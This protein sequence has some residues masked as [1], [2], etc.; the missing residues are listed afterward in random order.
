M[1][2]R[3]RVLSLSV[4]IVCACSA[5]TASGQSADAPPGPP[6]ESSAVPPDQWGQLPALDWVKILLRHEVRLK[7]CQPWRGG[8]AF[9]IRVPTGQTLAVS[10]W[11]SLAGGLDLGDPKVPVESWSVSRP[12][13]PAV[14]V[15][16][17]SE[18]VP[19]DVCRR[20]LC[21]MVKVSDPPPDAAAV[22]TLAAG[23]PPIRKWGYFVVPTGTT[24]ANPA[25][26]PITVY[27]AMIVGPDSHHRPGQFCFGIFSKVDPATMHDGVVLDD[28]GHVL[29][30]QT[31]YYPESYHAPVIICSAVD[32]PALVAAAKLPPETPVATPPISTRQRPP[33][34]APA[35]VV[36]VPVV[37]VPVVA[38]SRPSPKR[39]A[40][41]P[42]RS[43]LR[44]ARMYAAS[45]QYA[46]ARL[47]FQR[48]VDD[49][50]SS[51][52]AAEARG[53]LRSIQDK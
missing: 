40:D 23:P 33:T 28:Q 38:A 29:G 26:E 27:R 24:A 1:F 17:R 4:L 52:A 22:L 25:T 44:L 36:G 32:V 41:D 13:G 19:N 7:G 51:P 31:G 11:F 5:A 39:P 37:G 16:I 14:P 18:V 2:Q 42:A 43:L 50:P 53:D 9:L 34:T 10:P 46:Q 45:G 20:L 15:V 12:G 47:R 30:L 6:P 21:M 35:T 49:Y 48:V 3:P 8:H